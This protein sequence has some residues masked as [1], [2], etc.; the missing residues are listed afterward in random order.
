[1]HNRIIQ[2]ELLKQTAINHPLTELDL[3]GVDGELSFI[4]TITN[5]ISNDVVI[6]EDIKWI[7]DYLSH[8]V[9]NK[10]FKFNN[11]ES[12]TFKEGFK[13]SYF[14]KKFNDFKSISKKIKI[15]N[16][17][18]ILEISK[19]SKI[20]ENTEDFYIYNK[21]SYMSLDNF[22]RCLPDKETTFYFGTTLE[23]Y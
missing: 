7:K 19:L 17:I 15:D 13:K 23:Y 22:I 3:I 18:N 12:I 6:E 11:Y 2:L 20:I 8:K 1:M 14:E 16:F 10:F 9:D 21:N 4:G 5:Y